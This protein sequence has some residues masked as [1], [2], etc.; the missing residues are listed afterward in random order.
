MDV[1]GG[2]KRKEEEGREGE[3]E[4]E[5]RERE[6]REREKGRKREREKERKREKEKEKEKEKERTRRTP[7]LAL[8][9]N[10]SSNSKKNQTKQKAPERNG[11][12]LSFLLAAGSNGLTAVVNARPLRLQARLSRDTDKGLKSRGE[13]TQ[14]A[15]AMRRRRRRAIA[16]QANG[17][18]KEKKKHPQ[19]KRG[20][21]CAAALLLALTATSFLGVIA[22]N[23]HMLERAAGAESLGGE[24]A[25]ACLIRGACR[26]VLALRSRSPGL[27]SGWKAKGRRK[28]AAAAAAAAAAVACVLFCLLF[29]LGPSSSLKAMSCRL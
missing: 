10:S 3:R 12:W 7:G 26:L 9:E 22:V 16:T 6:K 21:E 28:V 15:A 19:P 23:E 17:R 29:G 18:E 8:L 27:V 20:Q 1:E 11:P 14:L 5:K 24:R 13:T 25:A 2:G 4:R